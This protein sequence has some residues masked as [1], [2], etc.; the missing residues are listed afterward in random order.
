MLSRLIRRRWPIPVAALV[1]V[2]AMVGAAVV[3]TRDDGMKLVIYNGR[4]HYGDE[5][6]FEDFEAATGIEV[7]LRGGSGGE[8]FDRLE[9]EGE[10]TPADV[11]ITTDLSNLWRADQ[12]GL[13]QSVTTPALEANVPEPLHQTDGRWW[14][15]STRLRVPMISTERVDPS[16]VTSYESLGDPQFE[17]RTC[18]RSSANEYNQSL[19]ADLLAKRGEDATRAL[20]ESWMANDP[21]ILTSDTD[22]LAAIEA[23]DCDLGLT[24]HYYLGRALEEDPRFPVEPAWPDQDGPGAHANIS[25]VGMITGTDQPDEVIQL[26]EYLTS[27]DGQRLITVGSELAANPEVPPADHIREW[28][29]V[30]QDPIAVNEAGPLLD[31]AARLMLDVGWR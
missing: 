8:L 21:E 27:V 10:D 22:L 18:L 30:R 13:L 14:A 15:L 28:A 16:A 6:V 19:V 2:L 17:G 3:V 25:G 20:L 7:E 5:Q 4:S 1:L 24:N 31:D 12:A 23:G 26:M 9:R 11:L 29:D